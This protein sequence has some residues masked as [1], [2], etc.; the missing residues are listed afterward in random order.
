MLVWFFL[1]WDAKRREV[2]Q[3]YER[4]FCKIARIKKKQQQLLHENDGNT[5]WVYLFNRSLYYLF[6]FN[7]NLIGYSFRK[8]SLA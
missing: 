8:L 5:I 2:Y 3:N 6:F 4:K 7:N 1:S